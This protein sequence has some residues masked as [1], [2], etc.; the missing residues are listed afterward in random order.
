MM[1]HR[2]H[3]SSPATVRHLQIHLHHTGGQDE[4]GTH[5]T[6]FHLPLSSGEVAGE[7]VGF[8]ASSARRISPTTA[9]SGQEPAV[10]PPATSAFSASLAILP[11]KKQVVCVGELD[12]VG[13]TDNAGNHTA[14]RRGEVAG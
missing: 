9:R 7:R 13:W 1:Q 10:S 3:W 8:C 12:A 14:V 4:A 2:H 6:N 11:A 5:Y